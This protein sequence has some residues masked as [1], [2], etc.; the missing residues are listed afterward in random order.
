[1]S[2]MIYPPPASGVHNWLFGRARFLQSRGMCA[3]TAIAAL[4]AAVAHFTFRPGRTVHAIE[5]RDAVEAA[6]RRPLVGTQRHSSPHFAPQRPS[7]FDPV[8]GW[9]SEM[10][11]PVARF[12]R[13][14]TARVLVAAGGFGVVDLWEKS[15]MRSPERR[16]P[17]CVLELLFE[18]GDLLCIGYSSSNFATRP[19]HDWHDGDLEA[20]QFIVPSPLRK[21]AG[22]TKR[23]TTSAHCRDAVGPRRF[24]VFESDQGLSQD[25]QAA[26]LEHLKSATAARLAVVVLS[27]GKSVHGWFDVRGVEAATLARWFSYAIKLGADPR[28]WLPEQFVRLPDGRRENGAAQSVVY[29]NP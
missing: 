6:F 1:M 11:C 18:P 22:V 24:I 21:A 29:L 8:T 9:P 26:I 12:D 10:T 4:E 7:I 28:L 5:V 17:R 14:A 19:L 20:A 25:Q 27:G 15:P 2:L 16:S 23:G 3:E 13:S